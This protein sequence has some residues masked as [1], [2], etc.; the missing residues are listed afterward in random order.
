VGAAFV[1]VVLL[2]VHLH[3]H[4]D[5]YG[6]L[7]VVDQSVAVDVSQ[8]IFLLHELLLVVVVNLVV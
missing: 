4:E 3:I 6:G 1:V 7:D 8:P 2:L 5:L